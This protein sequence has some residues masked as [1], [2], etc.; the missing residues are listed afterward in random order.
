MIE[1]IFGILYAVLS[2]IFWS[3][4]SIHFDLEENGAG[5]WNLFLSAAAGA[6]IF[7]MLL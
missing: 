3:R 7:L 6:G 4:A 1:I 5:Y 2:F